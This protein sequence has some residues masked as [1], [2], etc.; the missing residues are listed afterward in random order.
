[1]LKLR[2][3]ISLRSR[4]GE[5]DPLVTDYGRIASDRVRDHVISP[6]HCN[7]CTGYIKALNISNTVLKKMRE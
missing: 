7:A 6:I 5:L 2:M 1:M 3:F 4:R